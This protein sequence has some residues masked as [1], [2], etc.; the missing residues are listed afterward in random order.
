MGIEPTDPPLDSGSDDFEDREGH[1]SARHFQEEF[2][3]GQTGSVVVLD[4]NSRLVRVVTLLSA[5]LV[6]AEPTPTPC[7]F[8]DGYVS[9]SHPT[10]RRSR[11]SNRIDA[12]RC[13]PVR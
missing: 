11:P 4:G 6:G 9:E 13:L 10:N 2:G 5:L 7:R 3:V 8:R 1:Q 12:V